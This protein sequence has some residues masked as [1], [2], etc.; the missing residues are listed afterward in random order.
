MLPEHD[1]EHQSVNEPGYALSALLIAALVALLAAAQIVGVEPG[2]MRP[3]LGTALV[4]FYLYA[5]GGMFVASYYF[6][7][8]SIFLRGIRWVCEH[9]SW[10]KVR[11]MAFFYCLL[12]FGI[13]SVAVFT[14]FSAP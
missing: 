13:G 1:C 5:W 14:G 3:G 7:H 12:C 2:P 9:F 8:K 10:P 11:E 4:G 6:S